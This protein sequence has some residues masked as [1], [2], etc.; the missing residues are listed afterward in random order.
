MPGHERLRA[1]L[2]KNELTYRAAAGVSGLRCDRLQLGNR[3]V[4]P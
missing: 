1:W 4:A 2:N 3:Q